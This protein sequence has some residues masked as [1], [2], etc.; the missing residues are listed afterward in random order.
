M[1]LPS[2][3]VKPRTQPIWSDGS[4]R[5]RS[6]GWVLARQGS[7]RGGH[8]RA[9]PGLAIVGLEAEHPELGDRGE[10]GHAAAVP[11]ELRRVERHLQ[12]SEGQV[13]RPAL[14][15]DLPVLSCLERRREAAIVEIRRQPEAGVE[16]AWRFRGL[17]GEDLLR[18]IRDPSQFWLRVAG[19]RMPATIRRLLSSSATNVVPFSMTGLLSPVALFLPGTTHDYA[20]R[21]AGPSIL[22]RGF[23]GGLRLSSAYLTL[24]GW[25]QRS[26][27]TRRLPPSRGHASCLPQSPDVGQQECKSCE[28]ST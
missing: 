4:A 10:R 2:L 1:W 17:L 8:G 11:D 27:S 19:S 24:P 3:S 6:C 15:R 25:R 16:G 5:S 28:S 14:Q 23:N 21:Q 26:A 18:V 7:Q 20:I 9:E 13:E 22:S 12:L